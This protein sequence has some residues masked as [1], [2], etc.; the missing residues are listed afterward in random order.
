MD[1]LLLA[2]LLAPTNPVVKYF[3]KV[4]HKDPFR[5]IYHANAFS[6]T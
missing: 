2:I 4:F 6:N 5:G 1:Q 3:Y